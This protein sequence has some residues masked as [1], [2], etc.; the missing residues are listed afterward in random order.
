[1]QKARGTKGARV[2]I[3][4]ESIETLRGKSIIGVKSVLKSS[5]RENLLTNQSASYYIKIF[6]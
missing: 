6:K 3:H 2:A 5:L 1:M 4:G